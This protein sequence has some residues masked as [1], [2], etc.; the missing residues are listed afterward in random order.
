MA[1]LKYWLWLA[2]LQ[3]LRRQTRLSLLE[4][5]G[6]PEDIYYA[7]PQEVLLTEGISREQADRLQDKSLARAEEILEACQR[8]GFRILT[9]QDAEYPVRLR[10][11]YDPP[12]L[13]YIRG[14]F[15]VIDEEVAVAMVGTR[16]CTPY[17]VSCAEK[18]GG[19]LAAAGAVVVTGLARGVDSVS[20]KSALR[21]GGTVIGVLGCG[22]DVVYPPE[23]G[24][25][26]KDVA[27]AGALIS[28][29]A[30]ATEPLGRN[31]PVRNR[32]ISGLSLATLVVEAPESSGALI[33]AGTALEQSRDVY[34]VPGPI[35][36]PASR[37][38]NRL[39]RDGAGL[40]FDGWDILRD[41]EGR[42]PGKLRSES[43]RREPPKIP[44]YQSRTE[45]RQEPAKKLPELLS[46]SRAGA[47]LTE[48]Q[49]RILRTLTDDPMLVDDLIEATQLPARRVLSALTLLEID[50]YVLQSAG[51]RY[52]R[53][54]LLTD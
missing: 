14:R 49:I 28:E 34:A 33:T 4:H 26:Y 29:Y 36:A 54:V 42:Y 1:A 35:D 11:I 47:A 23:N 52:A 24:D 37:G 10:N 6:S 51:K 39:I 53:N 50:Q 32:I 30:P 22:L 5:F 48:D 13:L 46:L 44:G 20:A 21:S 41:Y 25:L 8:Q 12:C 19:Q 27:A 16:N 31:F 45:Q 18:L 15:P 3:G 7:D 43:A 2:E 40:V 17:G 9:L 38:C